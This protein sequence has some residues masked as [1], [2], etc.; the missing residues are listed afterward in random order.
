MVKEISIANPGV[1]TL[2]VGSK[3]GYEDGDLVEITN[4]EGMHTLTDPTKSINGTVHRIKVISISS[5]EIGDTTLFS[6]HIRNGTV[7]LVKEPL[8]VQFMP[9]S[10]VVA[11]TKVPL[12]GGLAESDFMKMENPMFTHIAYQTMSTINPKAWDHQDMKEFV[13]VGLQEGWK[14][15]TCD[16]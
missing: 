12:D 11:A 8:K 10:E 4:V 14:Y 9:L 15:P 6:S 2:L 1:C 16:S 7:K 5:F 3:H 13:N